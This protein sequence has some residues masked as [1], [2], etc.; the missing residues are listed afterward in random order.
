MWFTFG[1]LSAVFAALVT[2]VSKLGLKT[3]DPIFATTLR[4]LVM[5]GFFLIVSLTSKKFSGL[6][7]NSLSQ[8]DILLILASGLFGALSW[9]FYFLA[10]K[11][12]QAVRVA[13]LDR[14]SLVFILL[15]S[16]AFLGTTPTSKAIIGVIFITIGVILTT[17]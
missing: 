14:L 4:A 17:T 10:L 13:A 9:L 15:L 16:F 11:S 3:Q 7:L 12:G 1:I 6:S 5:A 2:V 8:K